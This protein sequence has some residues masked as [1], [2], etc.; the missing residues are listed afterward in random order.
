MLIRVHV[1][2]AGHSVP[3]GQWKVH[4]SLQQGSWKASVN[5]SLW[6]VIMRFGYVALP[7]FY[8]GISVLLMC[9]LVCLYVVIDSVVGQIESF[10]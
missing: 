1:D 6:I 10:Y 7:L 9:M 3:L 5:N 4:I 8:L 2:R